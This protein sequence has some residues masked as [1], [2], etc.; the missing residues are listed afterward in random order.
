MLIAPGWVLCP[1]FLSFH[2]LASTFAATAAVILFILLSCYAAILPIII[3]IVRKLLT[4]TCLLIIIIK[5]FTLECVI[6]RCCNLPV[7]GCRHCNYCCSCRSCYNWHFRF[8]VAAVLKCKLRAQLTLLQTGSCRF[9][10][11]S[12]V[13]LVLWHKARIA[14]NL[15]V[16]AIAIVNLIHGQLKPLPYTAVQ[17]SRYQFEA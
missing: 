6:V 1:R 9:Q 3:T 7:A 17:Q 5:Q 11:I 2:L 12:F 16:A 13:A 4:M 14:A 15:S 8:F 10:G